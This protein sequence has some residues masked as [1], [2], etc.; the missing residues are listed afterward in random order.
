MD[1]KW[2]TSGSF[3]SR[4]AVLVFRSTPLKQKSI[5]KPLLTKGEPSNIPSEMESLREH[6]DKEHDPPFNILSQSTPL[7]KTKLPDQLVTKTPN[8]DKVLVSIKENMGEKLSF[9]SHSKFIQKEYCKPKR[10]L[11]SSLLRHNSISTSDEVKISNNQMSL[12]ADKSNTERIDVNVGCEEES[13]L[14]EEDDKKDVVYTPNMP[15]FKMRIKFKFIQ[16]ETK[17]LRKIFN[18]HGLS[19]ARDDEN[20]SILWTGIHI[21]P[22]ILRNLAPY[23]RVNHFPRSYEL[24]RKDRLYKNI[25]R[26]QHFRGT[27]HFDI[28]PQSFI[29]PVE[30]K[31]LVSA[32]NKNRGPWIVKPAASSRGRGIFIV[33]TWLYKRF[34][35]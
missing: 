32:H 31:E 28:V 25:E 26:M 11:D 33:N 10:H 17:L 23:Q 7:L 3:G 12:I 2:I 16:T 30:Y 13:N 35:N 29:L 8:F 21:K 6:F 4:D 9:Q 34:T 18:R 14:S 1:S 19:E 15:A 22:D 27:K 5:T 20:F 24:T